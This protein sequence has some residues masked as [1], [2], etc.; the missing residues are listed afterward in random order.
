MFPLPLYR[1]WAEWQTCV[2]VAGWL[3]WARATRSAQRSLYCP[4]A[5]GS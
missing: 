5:V 3:A 1:T 2:A 4:P